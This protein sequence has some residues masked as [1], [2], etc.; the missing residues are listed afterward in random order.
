MK[1]EL[2]EHLN[3]VEQ[4][5]KRNYTVLEIMKNVYENNNNDIEDSQKILEILR[6]LIKKQ[7]EVLNGLQN[8]ISISKQV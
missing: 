1:Q 6:E 7:Q 8:F 4:L 2:I 3:N 5:V